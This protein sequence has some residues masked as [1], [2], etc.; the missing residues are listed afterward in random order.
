MTPRS[1]VPGSV[2]ASG[3]D[4]DDRKLV[5]RMLTGEKL[6]FDAFF[7]AYAPRLAAFVTRRA[8]LSAAAI[9]DI[10]QTTLVKA[11]HNLVSFRGEAALFTWVCEISRNELARVHRSAARQPALHSLD[12]IAAVRTEVLG[13]P[14][15][16]DRE[17]SNELEIEAHRGAVANTLEIL[18][19]RYAR[20]LEWKYGDGFSVQEIGRM[21][22]LTTAAAQSLLA[23]ARK[24]F[25]RR[26][27]EER[28]Q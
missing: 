5:A 6:A 13:L 3:F 2:V 21:L 18:P 24:E 15:P 20:A 17:P 4:D 23:R 1:E 9:E 14:A 10:V 7:A 8:N 27:L 25:R 16:A 22:G 28:P 26:W 11:V 12:G 19:H